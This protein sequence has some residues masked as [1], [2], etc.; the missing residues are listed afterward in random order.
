MDGMYAPCF[1]N[2]PLMLFSQLK[3]T[4]QAWSTSFVAI[5]DFS[6]LTLYVSDPSGTAVVDSVAIT[7]CISDPSS[8]A[9]T[10]DL[11]VHWAGLP[12]GAQYISHFEW[13]ILTGPTPSSTV[14][15]LGK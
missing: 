14:I 10:S 15:I 12:S 7:A 6:I 1:F 9:D 4:R 5:G 2:K 11:S 13:A 3:L 8:Q